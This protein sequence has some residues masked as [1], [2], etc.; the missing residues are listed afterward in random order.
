MIIKLHYLKLN[1]F[2]S[3]DI[4]DGNFKFPKSKKIMN[5]KFTFG[6]VFK[7]ADEDNLLL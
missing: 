6:S 3:I 7:T 2:K 4:L 5:K 1:K